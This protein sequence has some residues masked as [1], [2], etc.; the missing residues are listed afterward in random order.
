MITQEKFFNAVEKIK[1]GGCW[2]LG[3]L[4]GKQ[5]AIELDVINHKK[6]IIVMDGS[7]TAQALTDVFVKAFTNDAWV[8]LKIK[9]TIPAEVYTQ[10]KLLSAQNRLQLSSGEVVHQ[11]DSV[12]IVVIIDSKTVKLIETTYPAF[13]HLFGPV[14]T[15]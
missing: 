2:S 14:I 10:L 5:S 3:L 15:L 1:A 4:I 8:I 13:K 12:R 9:K 6:E 11:P 7:L